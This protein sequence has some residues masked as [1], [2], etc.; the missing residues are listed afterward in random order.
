MVEYSEY[1][2]LT[3]IISKSNHETTYQDLMQKEE[4]VLDTVN[5]VVKYYQEKK[6]NRTLFYKLSVIDMLH[7]FF[8][9][10][11]LILADIS[12]INSGNLKLSLALFTKNDRMIYIGI[13]LVFV[14]IIS[15]ITTVFS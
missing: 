11:S 4:K 10:W 5:S 15:A 7:L 3:D 8:T 14:A 12:K 9:E 2:N 6:T 13:M 1:K